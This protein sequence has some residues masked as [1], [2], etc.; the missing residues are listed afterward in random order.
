M[1][2]GKGSKQAPFSFKGNNSLECG[3]FYPSMLIKKAVEMDTSDGGTY[4]SC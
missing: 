2:L 4:D 1:A 3:S